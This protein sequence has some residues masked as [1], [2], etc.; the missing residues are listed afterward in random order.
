[1]KHPIINTLLSLAVLVI[2]SCQNNIDLSEKSVRVANIDRFLLDKLRQNRLLVIPECLSHDSYETLQLVHEI[3]SEWAESDDQTGRLLVGLESDTDSRLFDMIRKNRFYDYER[4]ANICPPGW[5][6]NSTKSLNENLFYSE[7]KDRFPQR[8]DIFGFE[9]SFHYYDKSKNEYIL[10]TEIDSAGN[11]ERI[12]NLES[13]APFI[14]KYIYSRFFRDYRSFS[15]IS[16]KM[17]ENP[18]AYFIIKVGNAHTLKRFNLNDTDR[19]IAQVYSIDTLKYTDWMGNFLKK[20]YSPVFIQSGFDTLL[21]TNTLF[22]YDSLSTD[23]LRKQQFESFMTDYIYTIAKKDITIIEEQPLLPIPSAAN[24][25]LLKNRNFQLYPDEE[26]IAIAERLVYFL[27]G[28]H[29]DVIPDEPG[30]TGACTFIDPETNEPVDFEGLESS[31]T[32]WYTDGTFITRLRE[33]LTDYNDRLL[34]KQIFHLMG[35][36]DFTSLTDEE[37]ENFT[38]HLLAILSIMGNEDERN[39]ARLRL[40]EALGET[41]GYYDYY[42]RYYFEKYSLD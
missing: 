2:V 25:R 33:N 19:Q 7:V 26:H 10:P 8:F 34:F 1:M 18:R 40:A 27:T 32:D 39:L 38:N 6:L 17:K 37:A 36:D 22:N 21:S 9:N 3:I 23:T 29:P 14:I 20:H 11:I 4:S 15:T 42:K 41:D 28:I 31:V 13:E 16:D 12:P 35:K 24:L 30:R 5:G